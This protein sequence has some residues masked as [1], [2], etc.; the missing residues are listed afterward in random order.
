MGGVATSVQYSCGS[1]SQCHSYFVIYIYILYAVYKFNRRS[2][3]TVVGYNLKGR[4]VQAPGYLYTTLKVK[5]V[6]V[7]SYLTFKIVSQS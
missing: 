7:A 2:N 4:R 3:T 6:E 5:I 1:L